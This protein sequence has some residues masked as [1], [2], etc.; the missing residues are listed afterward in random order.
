MS[1][2]KSACEVYAGY[3]DRVIT[4]DPEQELTG[5]GYYRN[6]HGEQVADDLKVRAM[7]LRQGETRLLL[8]CCDLLSFDIAFSMRMR[9]ALAA[10]HGTTRAGVLLACTH[11]HSGPTAQPLEGIGAFDPA[12]LEFVAG[13]MLAAAADAVADERPATVAH[14]MEVTEPIGYNRRTMTFAPIDPVLK[15]VVFTRNDRTLYLVN[16][17]CHP[18]TLGW[19]NV[20]S[21]DWPGATARALEV[22][23][24]RAVIF[25]GF[26]GDINPAVV[27]NRWGAGTS[28]DIEHMGTLLARK[29]RIGEAYAIEEAEPVLRAEEQSVDLP[30]VVP[31]PEEIRA[32]ADAYRAGPSWGDS[33]RFYNWWEQTALAHQPEYAAHPYVSAPVQALAIGSLRIIALPGE[34]FSGYGVRLREAM[35]NLLTVGYGNGNTGYLPTVDAYENADDYAAYGAPAFYTLFRFDATVEEIVLQACRDALAALGDVPCPDL[36]S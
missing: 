1:C 16:Y 15:S 35:P 7:S 27:L 14:R 23:G 25:Q 30:L 22:D 32:A 34:V 28:A 36:Q 19:T 26:C 9:E 17:A 4:P 12:Y 31:S 18:V 3:G 33:H 24:D 21:A 29:V 8:V 10:A 20:V 13:E 2:A 11:T 5:F 6:R